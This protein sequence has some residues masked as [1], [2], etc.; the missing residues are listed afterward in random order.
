MIW[1]VGILSIIT[2]VLFV[3]Y[4]KALSETTAVQ[5]MFV[6]AVLD[7]K[8]CQGQRDKIMDYLRSS[9]AN[10]AAELS[11]PFMLALANMAVTLAKSPSGSILLGAHAALWNAFKETKKQSVS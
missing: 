2:V 11:T 8:F 7:P 10:N 6:M 1:A 5:S 4:Q 9:E 3:L